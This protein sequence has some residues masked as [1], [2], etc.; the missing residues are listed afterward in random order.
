MA[1]LP[2]LSQDALNLGV[3][4][5]EMMLEIEGAVDEGVG[6]LKGGLGSLVGGGGQDVLADDDDTQQDQL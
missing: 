3:L 2:Q 5:I 1:K 4:S 6:I